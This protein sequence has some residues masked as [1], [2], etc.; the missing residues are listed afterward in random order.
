MDQEGVDVAIL[1][2]TRGLYVL[3][4]DSSEVAGQSGYEPKLAVAIARA[5]NDWLYDFCASDR[6][7]LF[8]AGMIAPHD[9][10]AAVGE[11]RRCV[12]ELA[13]IQDG[14][15]QPVLY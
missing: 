9:V 1:F 10:G 7:R 14:L 12:A 6:K 2:P 11:V 3:G 4:L 15:H 13:R 8:G 5:Y